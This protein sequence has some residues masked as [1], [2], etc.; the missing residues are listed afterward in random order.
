MRSG[1]P[2]RDWPKRS[3]AAR[4]RLAP[5]RRPVLMT[6]STIVELVSRELVVIL[7]R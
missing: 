4:S 3:L 1:S 5:S 2:A 7:C 6:R